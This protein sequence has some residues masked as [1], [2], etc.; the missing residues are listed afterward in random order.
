MKKQLRYALL[1]F[2]TLLTVAFVWFYFRVSVTEPL[3]ADLSPL[4]LKRQKLAEDF[5][6]IGNNWLK[7]SETGLW[8][9][10]VEGNPFERGVINGKLTKE[11][12]A[13]QEVDFIAE[14]KKIIPSE[15]YLNFLKYFVAWFNR[16]IENH[17]TEEYKLEIFGVSRSVPDDYDFVGPKYHR[18]LNYHA[19]HDVGHALQNLAMVGCTSFS[20]WDEK[21]ADSSLIVG[22]NFDFYVGDAFAENKIVCF[23]KPDSGYKFMFVGWGGMVGAVSGMNEKGLTV[24]INAGKSEMPSQGKTPISLVAREILQYAKNISEAYA[25]AGQRETFV[26]ESIMVSS[27]EDDR[28]AIIEKTPFQMGLYDSDDNQIICSNHF[29]SDELKDDS[30]NVQNL[31]ESDSPYRYKRVE[32]LLEQNDSLSVN[33]VAAILRDQKGLGGKDLGMGN[34]KAINLLF[35]HHSIIFKP[36]EQLVWVST[37][38]WQLGE[39]VAYDLNKIFNDYVGLREKKE[40][41][42]KE[43]TIPA[44]TFLLTDNYQNFLFFKKLK[45]EIKVSIEEENE[46]SAKTIEDFLK[47]NPEYFGTWVLAGKHYQSLGK[48]EK[49]IEYF[50]FALTKEIP[51][52]KEERAIKTALAECNTQK[53]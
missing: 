2:F 46:L 37:K 25:I 24:T 8:E 29:Q 11:L 44:D 47:T 51:T 5:Y 41:Y 3:P 1:S 30:L 50:N 26:S 34:Q 32:E 21:S 23:Y 48:F 39:Y 22:R 12:L 6:T 16:D 18:I 10:Y 40:I 36:K 53:Q 13:K 43:L 14:I 31:K 28:T 9:L 17:I 19:A 52:L 33:K 20:T 15:I 42:E 4:K 35:A 7:R 27:A 45:E 49:A 38:P